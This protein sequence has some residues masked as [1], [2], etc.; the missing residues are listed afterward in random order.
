MSKQKTHK[1]ASKRLKVTAK[2][3]LRHKTACAGHLM[4]H[5]TGK[6]KR[7]LRKPSFVEGAVAAR[8]KRMMGI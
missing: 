2:G 6:R 1:G 7:K 5:K 3:R 4:S 8:I